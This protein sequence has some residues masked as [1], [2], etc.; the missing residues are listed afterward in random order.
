MSVEKPEYLSIEALKQGGIYFIVLYQDCDLL[1]P[2]VQ[3]LQF[4]DIQTGADGERMALFHDHTLE[5]DNPHGVREK[6]VATLLRDFD[7][8]MAELDACRAR[9]SGK[10]RDSCRE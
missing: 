6:L 8:L 2:F 10:A 7:G 5:S 1:I 4:Y 3:T 9:H